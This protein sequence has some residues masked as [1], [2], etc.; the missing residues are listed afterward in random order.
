LTVSLNFARGT[1]EELADTYL[2]ML[3]KMKEG[4]KEEIQK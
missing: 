2:D 3:T 4:V 1:G